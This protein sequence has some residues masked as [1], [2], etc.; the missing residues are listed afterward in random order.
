[1]KKTFRVYNKEKNCVYCEIILNTKVYLF[2]KI[3]GF[4]TQEQVTHKINTGP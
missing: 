4:L 2:G 1:M 3:Q